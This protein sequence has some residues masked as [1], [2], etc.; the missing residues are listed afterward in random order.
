MFWNTFSLCVT[1]VQRDFIFLWSSAYPSGQPLRKAFT[2]GRI[3]YKYSPS[4]LEFCFWGFPVLWLPRTLN[5]PL[6]RP[7]PNAFCGGNLG[8]GPKD[9]EGSQKER[10][11]P[12]KACGPESEFLTAWQ[13]HIQWV[14]YVLFSALLSVC[15]EQPTLLATGW[16]GWFIGYQLNWIYPSAGTGSFIG[17]KGWS[18]VT[19]SLHYLV[20]SFRLP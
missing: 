18:I 12:S 2:R 14:M 17:D 4:S 5:T 20:I 11:V 9:W 7:G 1:L 15:E 6:R 13:L 3:L 19:L 16:V 8:R 10:R